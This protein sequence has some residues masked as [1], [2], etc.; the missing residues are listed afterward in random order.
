MVVL[1]GRLGWV[2][3]PPKSLCQLPPMFE[4]ESPGAPDCVAIRLERGSAVSLFEALLD[5]PDWSERI[6]AMQIYRNGQ[7]AFLAGDSFH[8]ECISVWPAAPADLLDQ[9]VSDG[10]AER[11]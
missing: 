11:L 9:L 2:A 7:R 6:E 1:E 4:R 8:E 3:L 10:L 5:T